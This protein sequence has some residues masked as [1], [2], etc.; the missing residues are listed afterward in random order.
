MSDFLAGLGFLLIAAGAAVWLD[1]LKRRRE[2]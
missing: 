1:A 2:G